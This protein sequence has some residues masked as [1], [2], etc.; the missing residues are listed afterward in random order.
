MATPQGQDE[1]L[2]RLEREAERSRADLAHTVGELHDR[3]TPQAIKEDVKDY[4]HDKSQELYRNVERSA[5]DNPLQAVAI[6]AGLAYP[7]FRL[8]SSIPVPILL[9]GAGLALAK[10]SRVDA[11]SSVGAKFRDVKDQVQAKIAEQ[12]ESLGQH[13]R[14]GSEAVKSTAEEAAAQI[15]GTAQRVG[16]TIMTE[17]AK[18]GSR[19]TQV[20]SQTAESARDIASDAATAT[21]ETLSS[22]Y[23]SGVQAASYAGEQ[24]VDITR[25]SQDRFIEAIERHPL[26]VGG[27]GLAIGALIA[28]SLPATRLENLALGESSDGLKAKAGDLAAQGIQAAKTAA[29]EMY[30]DVAQEAKNQGLTSES[31]REAGKDVGNKVASAVS[32]AAG[33][34]NPPMK[35]GDTVP[36]SNR[37]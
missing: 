26:V 37:T 25:R 13:I 4:V 35:S 29:G 32:R 11:R 19:A 6:A 31:V 3:V 33:G 23:H 5:R 10:T 30:A 18:L 24:V 17:A 14:E 12:T 2:S 27:I 20:A 22:A 7:I 34:I 1:S 16:S 8:V 15:T 36:T 28:S 21:G 9:V